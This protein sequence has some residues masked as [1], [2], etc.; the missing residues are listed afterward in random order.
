MLIP[1]GEQLSEYHLC[2]DLNFLE[3]ESVPCSIMV[4]IPFAVVLSAAE[5]PHMAPDNPAIIIPD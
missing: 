2:E 4:Q 3:F 5:K 1:S